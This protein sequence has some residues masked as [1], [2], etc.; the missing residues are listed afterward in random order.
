[1]KTRGVQVR[2]A[3]KDLPCQRVLL[4]GRQRCKEG[5]Q[6]VPRAE[7]IEGIIM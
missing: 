4:T 1:M 2:N 5:K 3:A 6:A 7:E